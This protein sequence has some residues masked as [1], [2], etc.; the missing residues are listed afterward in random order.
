[1]A[2]PKNYDQLLADLKLTIYREIQPQLCEKDQAMIQ[3]II[4]DLEKQS[5]WAGRLAVQMAKKKLSGKAMAQLME[6]APETISRLLK[7]KRDP[8]F[9]IRSIIENMED[10]KL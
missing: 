1:M 8:D 4:E 7:G 9:R 5:N 6:V 10:G 3:E 2:M